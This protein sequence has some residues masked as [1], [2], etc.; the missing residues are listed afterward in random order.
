MRAVRDARDVVAAMHAL[1]VREAVALLTRRTSRPCGAPTAASGRALA[2]GDAEAARRADDELHGVPV[3]V[4]G[5]Q[6]LAAVLEQ[7]TPLV[8]AAPSG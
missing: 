1:A 7:F 8:H 5:N 4:S 2:A 3:T 6:A